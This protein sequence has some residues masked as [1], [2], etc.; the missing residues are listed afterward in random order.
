DQAV[1]HPQGS[2]HAVQDDHSGTSATAAEDVQPTPQEPET[3]SDGGA[4]RQ[5][6]EGQ[7][8]SLQGLPLTGEARQQHEPDRERGAGAAPQGTGGSF[9]L[10]VSPERNRALSSRSRNRV[11]QPSY[12]A[13]VRAS[14]RQPSLF[15]DLPPLEPADR[16]PKPAEPK[17]TLDAAGQTEPALADA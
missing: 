4:L 5:G 8:S 6:V 3:A 15:D 11:H 16:V 17:E 10:R 1:S 2:E 9:A 12:T 7:S 13:R 14:R